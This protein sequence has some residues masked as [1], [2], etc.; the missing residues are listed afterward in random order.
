MYSRSTDPGSDAIFIQISSGY[1]FWQD[2]LTLTNPL[3]H[4]TITTVPGEGKLKLSEST[5]SLQTLK[6][7]QRRRI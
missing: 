7:Y 3:S 2:L 5:G 6:C 1:I 4:S